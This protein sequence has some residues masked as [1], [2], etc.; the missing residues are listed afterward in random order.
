M[1]SAQGLPAGFLLLDANGWN[2]A[3]FA[4]RLAHTVIWAFMVACILALPV[5]AWRGR[6]RL[7][8]VLSAIVLG[9]CGLLALNHRRCPLTDWRRDSR[10]S[11]RRT[12]TFICPSGWRSTTSSFSGYC[13][14]SVRLCCWRAGCEPAFRLGKQLRK[15][16]RTSRKARRPAGSRSAYREFRDAA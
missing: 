9:E 13:S 7:G 11:G 16:K 10:R 8:A 3:L 12:S 2:G 6:F 5:A 14:R 1:A 4:I 15:R